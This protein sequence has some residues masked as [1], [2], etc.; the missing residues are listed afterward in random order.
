MGVFIDEKS[1]PIAGLSKTP[2]ILVETG[3]ITNKDEEI[4]L[5][6]ENGQEQVADNVFSAIK[7]YKTAIEGNN[8]NTSQ[9][10][11]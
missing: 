1:N 2:T 9:Y 5:N 11:Q 3:F 6:S 8:G 7:R 4:Y 10:N